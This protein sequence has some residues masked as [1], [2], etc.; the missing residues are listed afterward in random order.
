MRVL[1]ISDIHY[2][3]RIR[4]LPK[5]DNLLKNHD[6]VFVLG[7]LTSLKVIQYIKSLNNKVEIVSGNMDSPF[8]KKNYPSIKYLEIL[9]HKIVLTHGWGSPFNIKSKILKFVRKKIS[10][11]FE[12]IFYGH[13]HKS[14]DSFYKGIRFIN[15]GSFMKKKYISM[16][17]TI[18]EINLKQL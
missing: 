12:I 16:N 5:I 7:D 2:P 4:T 11:E 18:G 8:I 14:N 17:I 10:R 3:D 9:G 13:T 15:P 6:M 1:I